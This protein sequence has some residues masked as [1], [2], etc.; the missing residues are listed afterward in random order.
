MM[1]TALALA[2]QVRSGNVSSR[3]LVETALRRVETL[4]PAL[5]AVTAVRQAAAIRE[6]EKLEDHGSRF[7]VCRY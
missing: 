4:N 5:N 7:L 2:Q 1:D 6:A 3:E